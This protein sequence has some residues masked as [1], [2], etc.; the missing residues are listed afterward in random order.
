LLVEN[1]QLLAPDAAAMALRQAKRRQQTAPLQR[2][3][4]EPLVFELAAEMCL[5]VGDVNAFDDLAAG[6][7]EPTTEF[8]SDGPGSPHA[9]DREGLR[10][11][12]R[13]GQLR[14][15]SRRMRVT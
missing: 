8:H 12:G 11:A 6:G 1:Q 14:L 4:E 13:S 7:S 9:L 5:A 15:R 3:D 10:A 2:Q